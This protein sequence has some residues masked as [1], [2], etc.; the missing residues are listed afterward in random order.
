MKAL[1]ILQPWAFAIAEGEKHV[2]NRTWK[3]A[4]RGPLAIHAGKSLTWMQREDPEEWIERYGMALPE[5]AELPFGAIVAVAELMDCVR[6]AD[7]P[8][9][10]RGHPFAEGPVCWILRNVRKVEPIPCV[11]AQQVWRVPDGIVDQ[12][13]NQTPPFFNP[14]SASRGDPRKLSGRGG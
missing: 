10:L 11:G 4:H 2:E 14:R 9:D 1:T 12:I 8:E 3:T 6:L 7:L 5:A 13:A